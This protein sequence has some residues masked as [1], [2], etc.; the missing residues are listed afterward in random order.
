MDR[1]KLKFKLVAWPAW[2]VAAVNVV[3]FVDPHITPAMST[4][5]VGAGVASAVVWVVRD[6]QRPSAHI[7]ESGREFGRREAI[8]ESNSQARIVCLDEERQARRDYDER[9]TG[10]R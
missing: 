4:L 9:R 10:S 3:P 5:S 2:T 8:A 7:W 6:C 1:Q